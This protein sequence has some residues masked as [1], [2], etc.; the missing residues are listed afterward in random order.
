M[1]FWMHNKF[2]PWNA[3]SSTKPVFNTVRRQ[4]YLPV[5]SG[6]LALEINI[7]RLQSSCCL[8]SGTNEDDLCIF[9]FTSNDS[10][11]LEEMI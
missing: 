3:F 9:F 1:R 8:V 5:V 4:K 11:K 10:K 7:Q 6:R 2:F